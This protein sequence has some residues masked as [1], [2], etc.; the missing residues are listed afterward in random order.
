M[1]I[2]SVLQTK[3]IPYRLLLCPPPMEP[4]A[5][6]KTSSLNFEETESKSEAISP[7]VYIIPQKPV[8][9]HDRPAYDTAISSTM[10]LIHTATEEEYQNIYEETVKKFFS[11]EIA[12]CGPEFEKL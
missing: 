8:R 5:T 9:E 4:K 10:G 6:T 3:N 2:I 1:R 7:E 11:D 12:I